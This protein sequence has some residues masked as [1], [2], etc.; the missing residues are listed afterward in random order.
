MKLKEKANLVQEIGMKFD[1]A[2]ELFSDETLQSISMNDLTGGVSQN[3][4][5]GAQCVANC[6]GQC[7]GTNCGGTGS[8]GGSGGSGGSGSSGGNTGGS[9]SGS[10]SK[11]KD[12]K[13]VELFCGTHV[14]LTGCPGWFIK[15]H[16]IKVTLC[17]YFFK[18]ID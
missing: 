6:Q 17:G 1:E 5:D 13:E 12:N 18:A 16:E 7:G 2:S 9:S 10:T 4:C 3:Y 11:S 15:Q 8:S 14:A